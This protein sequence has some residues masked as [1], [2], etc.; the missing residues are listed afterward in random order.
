MVAACGGSGASSKP[1]AD[2][3][4]ARPADSSSGSA[5]KKQTGKVDA[6]TKKQTPR[7]MDSVLKPKFIINEKTGKIDTIHD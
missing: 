1:V 4:R 7:G 3:L 2:T 6:S 5:S